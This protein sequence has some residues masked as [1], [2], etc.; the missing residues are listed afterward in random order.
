MY[1][2]KRILFKLFIIPGNV[3]RQVI[4]KLIQKRMGGNL[5]SNLYHILK[6]HTD[7]GGGYAYIGQGLH[8][9]EGAS[10]VHAPL[11][12]KSLSCSISHA[13]AQMSVIF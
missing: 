9:S 2:R 13:C 5:L 4:L 10:Y 8:S 11:Y 6:L 7:I 12:S 1:I 3:G